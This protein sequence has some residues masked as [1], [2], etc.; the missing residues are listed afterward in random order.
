MSLLRKTANLLVNSAVLWALPAMAQQPEPWDLKRCVDYA[1]SNNISVRQAD[2]QKRLSVLQY[3]QAK[4]S[5]YPNANFSTNTGFQFGRSI[6][7]TTN[8]FTNQRL[9]FQGFQFNTDVTLYNWGRVTHNITAAR[10]E[11]EASGSDVDK[12]RNDVALNV[13][14]A[15][16]QALLSK[17][18][19]DIAAVQVEQSQGQLT[20][21]RKRVDAG[22]LPELN[23]VDLEAQLARDSASL[24]TAQASYEQ[25][26][27]LL[28]ALL[29]LGAEQPFTIAVPPVEQ[30]PIEPFAELQPDIVYQLALQNQPAQKANEVRKQSLEAGVKAARA[31]LYPTIF[32]S[33]GLATNFAG[34]NSKITG[35]QFLGYNP[36]DPTMGAIT[37]DGQQYFLQSPN[38]KITQG[39]KGFGE[40]WNGWGTQ[41]N[42]NFRQNVVVGVSVPIFNGYQSRTAYER[43]KLNVKSQDLVIEQS[44]QQLK[45]DIYSAYTNAVSS[46]QKFNASKSSLAATQKAYDFAR[47]RYDLGLLSTLE[48]I[49][50]Q[51]NL[52]RAKIDMANAQFDYVF[53]MKVLEFYKGMGIKL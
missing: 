30:I 28:K 23:A 10:L 44:N 27:I 50:S 15:Y 47:R 29:N 25:N 9:L 40:M 14:T 38:V 5:R 31:A 8:Q 36:P 49:T 39:T 20:D 32:G 41:M 46:M 22:T 13:A 42:N 51:N 43:S 2:I 21:T 3:E 7:P 52:T 37:V 45:Q 11:A 53:R 16:L 34:T 18:Q 35:F 1:V 12:A 26:L 17:V 4:Y 6:D 48:L 19:I 33:G 24:I